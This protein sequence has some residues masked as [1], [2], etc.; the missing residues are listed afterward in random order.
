MRVVSDEDEKVALVL[1]GT[2]PHKYLIENLKERGYRTVLIDYYEN[3]PAAVIADMHIRESTLDQEKVLEI[4]QRE[5][6]SLVISG[7]VD[8]ANVTACY[9]AEKLGLPAPYSYETALR[10]TDKELMKAGM[11]KAGVPTS[12]YHVVSVDDIE[13]FQAS[14]YPLVVKPSDC[15]GSKGVQKVHNTIELKQA[16]KEA[17]RLSRT[18]KSIVESFNVGREINAYFYIK[19][20]DIALLFLKNKKLPL[21]DGKEILRSFLNFGPDEI[22]SNAVNLLIDAVRKI[23]NEFVL[24]STPILVQAI[25]AE[26]SISVIEFAPRVGG[27]IAFRD[28]LAITGFDIIDS[29][30]QSYLGGDV[31]LKVNSE[32]I[33]RVANIHLY[34]RSGILNSIHGVESLVGDGVI[35]EYFMHKTPGMAMSSDDLASR[36]RVMGVIVRGKDDAEIYSKIRV[37]IEEIK[38]IN[39]DGV[40]VFD[41]DLF[42]F[43]SNV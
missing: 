9:L 4:A 12:A 8:Q 3:P 20:D 17:C 2:I 43:L 10:V 5:K 39:T 6:A 41:R 40:D 29:V 38:I 42:C 11:L 21:V 24:K 37:M 33:G 32:F 18:G 34:G 14:S 23:K 22:S 19:N 1:G 36:N 31:D 28:I 26:D 13:Q 27:G 15:N 25:V 16:L 7:C 35:E 30:V